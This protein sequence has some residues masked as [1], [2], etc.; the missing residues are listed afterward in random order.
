MEKALRNPLFLTGLPLAVCG[1]AITAPGLWIP[2][3]VLMVCGWAKGKK[4]A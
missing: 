3:L 1:F 4:Q 2:G